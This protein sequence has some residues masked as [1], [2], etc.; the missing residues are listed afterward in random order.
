MKPNER[1]NA[2]KEE[3]GLASRDYGIERARSQLLA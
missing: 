1:R 2:T 3:L